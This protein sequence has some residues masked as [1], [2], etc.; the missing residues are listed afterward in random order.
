MFKGE[1]EFSVGDRVKFKKSSLET[2]MIDAK[3][4]D[5]FIIEHFQDKAKT[6]ALL[7]G[8]YFAIYSVEHLEHVK[9]Q[10]MNN[11]EGQEI[12]WEFGQEVWDTVLGK[13]EVTRVDESFYYPVGVVFDNGDTADYTLQGKIHEQTKRSLFFSEPV[14]TAELFPPKKPFVPTLKK[15]DVLV[16]QH[17]RL[18]EEK[19]VLKVESENEECVWF[20]GEDSGY[21]KTAWTFHK[22]GEEIKFES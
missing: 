16:V 7:E 22:L 14:I 1:N 12:K 13:G 21:L 15:G 2:G 19:Y 11:T 4:D 10:T 6:L 17:V 20:V 5:V 18:L 8:K 3:E 9:E